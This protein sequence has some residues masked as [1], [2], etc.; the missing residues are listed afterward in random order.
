MNLRIQRTFPIH[1]SLLVWL[2]I[3]AV[4]GG[5]LFAAEE[6]PLTEK[7]E[8]V[9]EQKKEEAKEKAKNFWEKID[10]ARLKNRTPNELVAWVIMGVLVAAV[11]G[12]L[13]AGENRL[14]SNLGRLAFGLAGAFIGGGIVRVRNLDL[15][16]GAAVIP[17]EELLF[18]FLGALI[19]VLL[20]KLIK[21]KLA[22]KMAK[23]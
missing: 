23:H 5:P 16:W 1:P 3:L 15:G 19:I 18:S 11:I 22:R 20:P 7:A 9:A 17:Y 6:S 13:S 4:L 2:L 14:T 10:E 21:A 8:K 12:M